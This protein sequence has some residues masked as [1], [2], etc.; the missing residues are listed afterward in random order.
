MS[1]LLKSAAPMSAG[2]LFGKTPGVLADIY[3]SDINLVC[4]QRG[5]TEDWHSDLHT[6]MSRT[7]LSIRQVV[8]ID[9]ATNTLVDLL[10]LD[11]ESA[12]INDFQQL[13]SMFADLFMLNRIG[14]RL[15]KIDKTM[16]PRF[17]T[18]RLI[19]RLVTTYLGNGT[20]WLENSYVDR[21]KLGA[22]AQGLPDEHSG[23]YQS[24][25]DINSAVA[26]DV[27]LLK[28]DG[29]PKAE[30]AGVIHRSPPAESDTPRLLLTLDFAD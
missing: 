6:L 13:I 16:C 11:K 2:S 23:I 24:V 19:C 25:K 1:A 3:R 17:H 5:V 22:G 8:D 10:N 12:L 9:D 4:W 20:Q 27:L 26:G 18:D 30:N 15:E 29:W 21:T 14:V 28:G 7:A